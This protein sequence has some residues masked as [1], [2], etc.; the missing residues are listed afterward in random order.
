MLSPALSSGLQ[1][2]QARKWPLPQPLG[3]GK[4]LMPPG[5]QSPKGKMRFPKAQGIP[6][7]E[8]VLLGRP[9]PRKARRKGQRLREP[10]WAQALRMGAP[11]TLGEGRNLR[12]RGGAP[13]LGGWTLSKSQEAER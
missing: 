5:P 3:S 7:Q 4:A 9:R 1:D 2:S 13:G 11:E 12:L 8:W 10:G 6:Q